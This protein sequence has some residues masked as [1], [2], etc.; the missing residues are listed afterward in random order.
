[1]IL[2]S[3]SYGW[4]IST[5][6]HVPIIPGGFW[7]RCGASSERRLS[8]TWKPGEVLLGDVT[9]FSIGFNVFSAMGVLP[10]GVEC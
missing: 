1:M 6:A 3:H 10:G 2:R 8:I 7:K 9:G 4:T 5:A